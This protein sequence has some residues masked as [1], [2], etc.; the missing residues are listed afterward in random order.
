MNQFSRNHCLLQTFVLAAA[1]IAAPLAH[2]DDVTD[3]YFQQAI[4][5]YFEYPQN[6]RTF[7][8]AGSSVV[9]T[10]SSASI[11]GNPAG[12]G[13]MKGG[14]FS[15]TYDN[16]TISGDEFPT[17]AAV[18][19]VSNGGHALLA[20]PL[21]PQVDAL[22]DYGNLG[23]GWTYL[24]SEWR[25]DTFDTESERTQV[26]LAY[27][28][29]SSD[30]LSWGYSLGWTDDRFQAEQIFNYPMGD[31][32]RHT[33]GM[34]WRPDDDMS[35]GSTVM[36]GHGEH[37]AL[38][39]PGIK[40]ESDTFE[41]GADIGV[42]YWIDRQL[43]LSLSAN[44]RHLNTDGEI[45]SSIPANVVGGDELGNI[46]GVRAGMEYLASDMLALRAGYRFAG[47]TRYKY[48]RI[49]LNDLNGS[50]NYS[51]YTLGAGL[52]FS[53][54]SNYIRAVD[55]DYG[56]EYRHVG[57]RDWQHVVTVSMPFDLCRPS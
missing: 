15:G 48:N 21:G 12:L 1:L 51:A 37:H 6:A 2:A 45:V 35:L 31:G 18:E 55:I 25:D 54:D 34:L 36:V 38:F 3:L 22:P 30:T 52:H 47:L 7:G 20:V 26:V 41:V 53:L 23:F 39:G 33:L 46:F 28:M 17:R 49:E 56:V 50:A 57:E 9:T 5:R 19:Q 8:M 14:E 27:A 4:E 40:G 10:S 16:N 43:A 32:F 29:P 24:S 42:S 13:F 11:I 44:Y